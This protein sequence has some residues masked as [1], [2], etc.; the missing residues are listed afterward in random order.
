MG[1]ESLQDVLQRTVAEYVAAN[2]GA[3]APA[4][5]IGA[6]PPSPVGVPSWLTPPTPPQ[7]TLPTPIGWSISIEFPVQTPEG[8]GKASADL[9]FSVESWPQAQAIVQ[10]LIYQGYP[11]KVFRP[12]QWFGQGQGWQNN[13]RGQGYNRWGGPPPN[14]QGNQWGR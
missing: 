5:A 10:Q 14:F 13:N 12:K 4:P 11:V 3:V 9:A 1:T 6:V 7:N 2:P 8:P